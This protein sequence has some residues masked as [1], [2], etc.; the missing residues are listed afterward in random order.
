[1]YYHSIPRNCDIIFYCMHKTWWRS[2]GTTVYPSIRTYTY[3]HS[4]C[5]SRGNEVDARQRR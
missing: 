2:K 1:M 4:G 5:V 3:M